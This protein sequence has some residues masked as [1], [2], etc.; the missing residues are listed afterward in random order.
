MYQDIGAFDMIYDEL[1]EICRVAWSE[2]I[3]YLC[4]DMSKK[5]RVNIVYSMRAKKHILNEFVK[6]KL[7]KN[8]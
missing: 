7:F 3:N 2:Q 4:I 6:V 5:M 1:K 8:F